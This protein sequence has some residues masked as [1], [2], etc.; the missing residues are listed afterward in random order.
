VE[1][2]ETAY[3]NEILFDQWIDEELLPCLRGNEALLVR[4]QASFHKTSSIL[5][6]VRNNKLF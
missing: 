2:N 6:K 5:D 3:N 4:D 1:F